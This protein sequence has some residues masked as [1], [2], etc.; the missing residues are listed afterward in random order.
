MPQ[1]LLELCDL[2][3]DRA[4]GQVQLLGRPGEAQM[5][6]G[7]FETLQGGH[8]WHQAFGHVGLGEQTQI[9]T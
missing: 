6:G 5:P 9:I 3:A 1:H 4:L 7:G 2:F 8:R